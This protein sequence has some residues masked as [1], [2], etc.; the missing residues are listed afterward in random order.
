MVTTKSTKITLYLKSRM[1][2]ISMMF[3]E[4][5]LER[6]WMLI[7]VKEKHLSI[8]N[9]SSWK[10][11]DWHW[12]LCSKLL[13]TGKFHRFPPSSSARR[14]QNSPSVSLHWKWRVSAAPLTPTSPVTSQWKSSRRLCKT[15]KSEVMTPTPSVMTASLTK[16]WTQPPRSWSKS[17]AAETLAHKNCRG[18]SILRAPNLFP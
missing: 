1:Q 14:S 18:S 4:I 11:V 6:T 7:L 12:T 8:W 17:C 13:T 3:R 2:M 16:L 10:R 9:T 15:T 5:K